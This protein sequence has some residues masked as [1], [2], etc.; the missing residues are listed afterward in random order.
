MTQFFK[1]I[2]R[3]LE[4]AIQTERVLNSIKLALKKGSNLVDFGTI[5]SYVRK[6]Q[7]GSCRLA[8]CQPRKG[9]HTLTLCQGQTSCRAKNIKTQSKD[10]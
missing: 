6:I 1:T 2:D 7:K 3:H 10:P 8:L 9:S 4:C 5:P